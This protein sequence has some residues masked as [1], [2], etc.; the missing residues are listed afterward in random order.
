VSAAAPAAALVAP[1]LG[2]DQGKQ[3]DEV[4]IYLGRVEAERVSQTM[5]D[6]ASADEAR[7]S[8]P[9]GTL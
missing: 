3:R 2:W 6:D 7:R 5:P 8:G 9:D 1:V 4:A